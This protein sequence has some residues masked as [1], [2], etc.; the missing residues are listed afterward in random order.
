MRFDTSSCHDGVDGW[1]EV[2]CDA[3]DGCSASV[4]A[5]PA[6]EPWPPAWA[7]DVRHAL[8]TTSEPKD[9]CPTHAPL[10]SA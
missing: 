3:P 10:A 7:Q 5:I 2:C 8:L 9:Y 6:G 4:D 1:M